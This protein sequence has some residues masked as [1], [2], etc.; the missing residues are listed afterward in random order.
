[1]V[2]CLIDYP[3]WVVGHGLGIAAINLSMISAHLWM[4]YKRHAR[5]AVPIS[6]AI[7]Q[8]TGDRPRISVLI[9]SYNRLPALCELIEILLD[10]DHDSFEVIVIEQSTER[11]D[12][13]VARL[14]TLEADP[15]LRI[16]R[17]PPLGG[18]RA[19]NHAVLASRA[20]LLVFV[21][22]DDLP[23]GREFLRNIEQVFVEEPRCAGLTCRQVSRD[24]ERPSILYRA[25]A[26][27][28]TMR[29]SPLLRMPFTYPRYHRRIDRV[30]YVHGTGGAFRRHVIERFGGWDED[31]PIEDEASLGFRVR[32]GLGADEYLCFDP[33]PRLRRRLALGGGL[34]K[35]GM[36]A[37]EFYRRLMTF[38]H[39]IVARYHPIRVR[40]LYPLYVAAGVQWTISWIFADSQRHQAMWRKFAGGIWFLITSPFH[41]LRMIGVGLGRRPGSGEALVAQLRE[42]PPA[43]PAAEQLRT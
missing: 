11:P 17:R 2:M 25:L 12:D 14:A 43:L 7:P 20:D 22:D 9:R 41:A 37:P 21:D 6:S 33:R 18:A 28:R 16:E 34:A 1:M 10:Q 26:R 13:A 8:A 5:V 23:V 32:R 36:T 42:L 24:E 19:R 29:F 38:V 39:H 35:R 15:R 40:L 31:T 30:H 4:S 27:F 3:N